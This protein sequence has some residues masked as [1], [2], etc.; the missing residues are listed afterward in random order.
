M[1]AGGGPPFRRAMGEEEGRFRGAGSPAKVGTNTSGDRSALKSR[2]N[3][4]RS[5][6]SEY[7]DLNDEDPG[8]T[9]EVFVLEFV[10]IAGN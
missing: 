9:S 4:R 2:K 3:V 10:S 8:S 1:L 6:A 7:W 5:V